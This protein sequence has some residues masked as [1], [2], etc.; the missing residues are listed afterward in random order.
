MSDPSSSTTV[1]A[2]SSTSEPQQQ[3]PKSAKAPRAARGGRPGDDETTRFSKTLSYILRHGAA[4]EFLKVRVDGF[5]KVDEL[6]KRP[7]LKDLEFS[8]L[9]EIV[10][11]DNK[12]RYTLRKEDGNG[13]VLEGPSSEEAEGEWWIRANQ[14][15]S[16]KVESLELEKVERAEDVPVVVHGTMFKVWS[17]IEKDGL[18]V[19]TRNHI[20]CATGLAGEKT[21]ISGMRNNCDLFIYLDVPKMLK[22]SVPLFKSTNGVILTPGV[23]GVL[24]PS[25][26]A[27]VVRKSGEVL[28]GEPASSS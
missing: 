16:I 23:D 22:D 7:K 10:K 21:V 15:H 5:V 27:R 6:L 28:V 24:A 19:M 25:Y 11:D 2:A 20:H 17:L 3:Q 8:K 4:K 13:A 9:Q 26:F 14:G 1:V 12:G 18:K